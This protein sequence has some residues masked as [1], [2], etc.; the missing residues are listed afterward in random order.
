ML[1]S[2]L[3]FPCAAVVGAGLMGSRIAAVLPVTAIAAKTP[4]PGTCPVPGF[5]CCRLRR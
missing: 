5:T 3:G 2:R 4:P 1:M